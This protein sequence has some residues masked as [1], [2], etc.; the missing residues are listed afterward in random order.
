VKSH[1]S[2]RL[3][4]DRRTYIRRRVPSTSGAIVAFAYHEAWLARSGT[5][6][7]DPSHGLYAG[8]QYPRSGDAIAAA[9][10]S[11]TAE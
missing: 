3:G 2:R 11:N 10:T 7:I 1:R 9:F 4:D 5:F 6:V 8:D